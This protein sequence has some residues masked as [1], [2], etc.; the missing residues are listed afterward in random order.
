MAMKVGTSWSD[1]NIDPLNYVLK[2][3]SWT[4]SRRNNLI[5]DKIKPDF[6]G[7][8][9]NKVIASVFWTHNAKE[10]PKDSGKRIFGKMKAIMLDVK[11][12]DTLMKQARA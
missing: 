6:I 5:P 10:K 12:P 3:L 8:A 11:C 7:S 4:T 9:S 1:E 2:R